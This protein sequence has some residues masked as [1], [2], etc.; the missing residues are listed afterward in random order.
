[1]AA[2][3]ADVSCNDEVAVD[4]L[5]VAGPRVVQFESLKAEV[6]AVPDPFDDL[7][8]SGAAARGAPLAVVQVLSGSHGWLIRAAIGKLGVS[9]LTH[10][11]VETA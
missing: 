6:A 5:P 1:M 3:G 9:T 8:E 11:F 2:G 7:P 4:H 10:L